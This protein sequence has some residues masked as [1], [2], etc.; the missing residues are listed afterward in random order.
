MTEQHP[1]FESIQEEITTNDIV[2]YM[3]GNAQS[4]MC[5]FS[6][7]VVQILN[8]LGVPFKDVDVLQD[9][10]LREAIKLFSDWPTIP[11]LYVKGEFIG[12][13]DIIRDMHQNHELE[14]LLKEKALI[15]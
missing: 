11:Q 10:E 4:P 15:A 14:A 5:G 9:Y 3:K 1:R 6:G 12:G 13:C 7:T 2:L 8:Q